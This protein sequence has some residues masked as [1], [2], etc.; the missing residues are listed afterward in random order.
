M[1]QPKDSIELNMPAAPRGADLPPDFE[2][3]SY[4]VE[5][6]AAN[7]GGKMTIGGMAALY[8]VYTNMGWYLET[9][10]PGFFDGAKTDRAA[11]LKNHDTNIVLGRTKNETLRLTIQ[12]NGLDY[13]ATLPGTQAAKDTYAEVEGGYIYESSFGFTVKKASWSE[14]DR[15]LLK[16]KVEEEVLDRLSYEGKVYVRELAICNELFDVSPVTYAQYQDTSVAKRS[17]D[18]EGKALGSQAVEA[19]A[20]DNYVDHYRLRAAQANARLLEFLFK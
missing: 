15:S 14:V 19:E 13:E 10:L 5:H 9:I 3:R 1:P 17:F 18:S 4:H 2:R 16:G 7:D 8:G 20:P 6:R 12:T 11:C